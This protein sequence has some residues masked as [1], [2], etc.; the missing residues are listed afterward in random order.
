MNYRVDQINTMLLNQKMPADN[1]LFDLLKILLGIFVI[2][3]FVDGKRTEEIVGYAY[4]CVDTKNFHH[5]RVKIEGEK[6][7]MTN[8]RLQE[9][10]ESGQQVYVEFDNLTVTV[11]INRQTNS[12]EDS[13]RAEGVHIVET[14]D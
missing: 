11:Y 6:P 7:L 8:E 3:R 4:D 14:E 9:L 13:F 5:I 10:R 2:Y 1:I 12:I